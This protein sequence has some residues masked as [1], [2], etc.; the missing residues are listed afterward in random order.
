MM[1]LAV[2]D[3]NL[4]DVIIVRKYRVLQ[5]LQILRDELSYMTTMEAI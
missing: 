3:V 5:K 2:H 1:S 4:G